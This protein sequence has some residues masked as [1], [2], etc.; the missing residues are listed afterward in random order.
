MARPRHAIARAALL[1]ADEIVAVGIATPVGVIALLRHLG[2][3]RALVPARA[4]LH[5]VVNRAPKG[6]FRRGEVV[7][8]VGRS[9]DIASVT[10]VP[11]DRRVERAAWDGATVAR[12]PFTRAV[13]TLATAVSDRPRVEEAVDEL[14]L[15][16][17]S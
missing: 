2:E 14:E 9:F 11:H 7:E 8:E 10:V 12:G 1:A 17:V 3:V 5:V 6:A 15:R 16:V 4:R 13:A